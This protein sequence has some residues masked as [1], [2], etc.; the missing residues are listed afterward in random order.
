MKIRFRTKVSLLFTAIMLISM[1]ILD[2]VV[3]T[4]LEPVFISDS[5]KQM[6]R[7][8][9]TVEDMLNSG[10]EDWDDI[11]PSFYE[12]YM[13]ETQIVKDGKTI[14]NSNITFR[15]R[16]HKNRNSILEKTIA[17]YEKSGEER[18]FAELVDD[19]DKIRRLVYVYQ[20]SDE[21]YIVMRKDMRG[22]D[23]NVKLVSMFLL[24]SEAATMLMGILIWIIVTR[25]FIRMFEKMIITTKNISELN[26]ENK[27]NYSGRDLEVGVLADSIDHLSDELS[28]NIEELGE[29]LEQKKVLL[30]N[31]AH[32]VKTPLTTIKG[33]TENIQ[34]LMPEQKRINR[35]C[36]IMI[37]ECDS[38]DFLANEMMQAASFENSKQYQVKENIQVEKISDMVRYMTNSITTH[39][40]RID[41]EPG[42]LYMN[43]EALRSVISN[44]LN[45]AVKYSKK[46]SVIYVEGKNTKN[47]YIFTVTNEGDEI[48]EGEK[49]LIWKPFYRLDKSRT[50]NGSH[51]IG[52]SMVKQI[53]DMYKAKVGVDCK[54]GMISF[55]FD[56]PIE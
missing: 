46:D 53:A 52:L 3:L 19:E 2:V 36:S 14:A 16:K 48:P 12:S 30:R 29:E 4:I 35:Y 51:G 37:D 28:R 23:Q 18:Y 33:Y 55:Y 47:S 31:L 5:K 43:L 32:E 20:C 40:I 41:M 25:P 17:D 27:I 56:I 50:R 1:L 38:L 9:N 42:V 8:S 44:Y 6:I 21:S 45:N 49:A 22:I 54:E 11:L 24:V 34:M 7:Y 13:I 26:F 39:E 10:M 15:D